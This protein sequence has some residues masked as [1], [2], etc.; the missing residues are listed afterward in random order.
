MRNGYEKMMTVSEYAQTLK[1]YNAAEESEMMTAEQ[2][3]ASLQ[4]QCVK[5]QVSSLI[6]VKQYV[7]SM[8]NEDYLT[9]EEKEMEANLEEFLSASKQAR[10]DAQ[11]LEKLCA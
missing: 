5:Y 10:K 2:Y 1:Q 11:T 4:T 8:N 3:A 7:E 6:T 9:A